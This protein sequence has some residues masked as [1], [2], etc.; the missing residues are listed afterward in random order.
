MEVPFLLF[1]G[2]RLAELHVSADLHGDVDGSEIV[3]S[4]DCSFQK[5]KLLLKPKA[6]MEA[7]RVNQEFLTLPPRLSTCL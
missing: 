7:Y 3:P 5:G 2:Q 4:G 1:V 6:R